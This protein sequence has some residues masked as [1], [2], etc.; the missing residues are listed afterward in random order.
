MKRMV[1]AVAAFLFTLSLAAVGVSYAGETVKEKGTIKAIDVKKGEIVFCPAGTKDEVPIKVGADDIK[2]LAAG[3]SVTV[4]YEKGD[5][6]V[7]ER[8]KKER[9]MKVPVGC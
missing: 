8:V 5:T 1:I 4:Q 6:N 9:K 7:A 2:G 3:D